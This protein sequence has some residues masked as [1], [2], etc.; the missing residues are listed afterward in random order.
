M[1]KI[2]YKIANLL[3]GCVGLQSSHLFPSPSKFYLLRRLL[4]VLARGEGMSIALDAA[5]ADFKYR[6]LFKTKYYIGV[7]IS[8]ENL[9]SG[10]LRKARPDDIGVLADLR[11]LK[12]FPAIADIVVST[13]TLAS[14]PPEDRHGGVMAL[15][16]AVA[17]NGILFFNM[18]KE[19]DSDELRDILESEFGVVRRRVYGERCFMAIENYFSHRTSSKR[20]LFLVLVGFS[21]IACYGLSFLDG[22]RNKGCY[23]LYECFN[24]KGSNVEERMNRVRT[25]KTAMSVSGY[26]DCAF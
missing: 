3:A 4:K 15:A 8:D 25:Y 21:I 22:R 10:L 20:N 18:P 2:L 17:Q 14:L 1:I 6:A 23:V 5:C 12:D 9:G 24:K 13:H 16:N 7:D 11:V 26:K 19:T